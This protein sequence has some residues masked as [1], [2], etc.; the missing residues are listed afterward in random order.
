MPASIGTVLDAGADFACCSRTGIR[1][2]D[3]TVLSAATTGA[4]GATDCVA[5]L[6]CETF[7][8]SVDG[9]GRSVAARAAT[10]PAYLP[11]IAAAPL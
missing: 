9:C 5:L 8:G 10:N 4:G 2:M 11:W 3:G 1:I 7:A 6:R